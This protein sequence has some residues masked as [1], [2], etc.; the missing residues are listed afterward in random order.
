MKAST[1]FGVV[2]HDEALP[3]SVVARV[4]RVAVAVLV[5]LALAAVV[6]VLGR[7]GSEAPG[8]RLGGD[9]PAF[10]G[11]GRIAADGDWDAL[12]DAGTQVAAQAD[13]GETQGEYLYFAYPPQV[14]A[15]YRTLVPFGYR[16]AHLL[17]TLLMAGAVLAS[18]WLARP[19][20]GWLRRLPLVV[21]FAV[22]VTLYP[23]LRAVMG[24][25]NSA[26]TLLLFVAVLRLE[27]E[28][29]PIASGA[30]AGLLLYKPQF[31]IPLALLIVAG[32]CSA[33]GPGL[34]C[35]CMPAA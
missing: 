1:E 28:H 9:L 4:T 31:G 15:A 22:A 20:F 14:A 24:G 10:Y 16:A 2:S 7:D 33:A 35:W 13:L 5:A 3:A 23:L 12:H 32:A 25:Q 34:R 27:Y 21:P 26:L 6:S 11:A 29:R 8:G 30:V 19:M 17:H 18:V